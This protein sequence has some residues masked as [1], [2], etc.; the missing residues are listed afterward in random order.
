MRVDRAQIMFGLERLL[1]VYPRLKHLPDDPGKL[2]EIYHRELG[3]LDVEAFRFA[4]N[5]Y[6]KTDA[7]YFPRPGE[8]RWHTKDFTRA[9]E[10]TEDLAAQYDRWERRGFMAAEGAGYAPCPVCGA[11]VEPEGRIRVQHDHQV[12]YDRRVGYLGPRTGPTDNDGRMLPVSG[13]TSGVA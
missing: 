1:E 7:K 12:H 4:V 11:T 9:P 13:T 8:L 5:A 3:D 10:P 6:C 2:A